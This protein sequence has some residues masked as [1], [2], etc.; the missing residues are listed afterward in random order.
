MGVFFDRLNFC[1]KAAL[2]CHTDQNKDKYRKKDL[3]FL[4]VSLIRSKGLRES[5]K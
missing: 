4:L 1:S 5:P 2:D 3:S